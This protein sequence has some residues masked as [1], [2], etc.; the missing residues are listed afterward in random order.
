M[1]LQEWLEQEKINS[2]ELSDFLTKIKPYFVATGFNATEFERKVN[3]GVRK[4]ETD[5]EDALKLE[6]NANS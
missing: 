6:P 2:P 4:T 5:I 1:T 3:I